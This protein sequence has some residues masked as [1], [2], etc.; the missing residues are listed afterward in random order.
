MEFPIATALLAAFLI[1]LQQSL[2][3]TAG[4]H[5]AKTGIGVGVGDDQ[6]LERKVRRHGNLAENAAILLLVLGMLELAGAP[7]AVVASFAVAFGAARVM[8][9]LG[10]GHLDGSHNPG[11]GKFWIV[12]RAGGA[13]LTGIGGIGLG[14]YLAYFLFTN[15]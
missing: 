3:F 9:A 11:G 8:H 14:I 12:M 4:M 2:M 5:R 1:V 7:S 13:T 6:H 10:F 15:M